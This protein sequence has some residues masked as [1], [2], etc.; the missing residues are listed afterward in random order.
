MMKRMVVF[1]W[2]TALC[3]PLWAG[4]ADDGLIEDGEYTSRHIFLNDQDLLVTGGGAY[5]IEAN[6]TGHIEVRKTSP[7]SNSGGITTLGLGDNYT[8]TYSGGHTG[9]LYF[10]ENSSGI[11]SGGQIN[12]IVSMQR[13][14]DLPH[15]TII[16]QSGWEWIYSEE[17]GME[18]EIVGITGLWDDDYDTPFLIN[19]H[20]D[21][22]YDPVY[23]NINVIPEPATLILLGVGGLLLRKQKRH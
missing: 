14:F 21:D 22:V 11:I 3:L 10:Y 7:L 1:L 18:D 9:A 12:W 15:I 17:T 20:N 2:I 5:S 13:V 23:M 6:G 19:F 16:C 8:L 4:I